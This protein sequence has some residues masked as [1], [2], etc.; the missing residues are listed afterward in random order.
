MPK[1]FNIGAE[2][3]VEEVLASA[4]G[5]VKP[6]GGLLIK[7]NSR[8]IRSGELLAIDTTTKKSFP[9]KS[10][11][12]AVAA[13]NG[14][15]DVDVD[16]SNAFEANDVIK[17]GDATGTYTISAINRTTHVMTL[18]ANLAGGTDPHPVDSRVHVDTDERNK[19]KA[20]ALSPM[21]DREDTE[22]ATKGEYTF[23]DCAIRGH[24]IKSKLKNFNSDSNTDFGGE[25]E[26]NGIYSIK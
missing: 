24:F 1:L 19:A 12:L 9:V 13:A 2:E 22:L 3:Q 23:G 14:Q 11:Q 16:D 4:I 25:D 18:T 10:S 8:K 20:I 17:V 21:I 15:A 26:A 7:A 6:L 5:V